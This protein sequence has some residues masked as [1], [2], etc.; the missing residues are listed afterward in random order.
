[1]FWKRPA[2][3]VPALCGF[4]TSFIIAKDCNQPG[5]ASEYIS[6]RC[7][8]QVSGR[9]HIAKLIESLSQDKSP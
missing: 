6:G 2:L 8:F 5:A 4:G 1:M 3:L 9:I 7:P